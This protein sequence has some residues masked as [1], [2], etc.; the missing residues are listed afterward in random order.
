MT[1]LLKT[2]TA[3][4]NVELVRNCK[5][6]EEMTELLNTATVKMLLEFNEILNIDVKKSAKKSEIINRIVNRLLNEREVEAFK[7][8]SVNKRVKYLVANKKSQLN[9]LVHCDIDELKA[10]V[11]ALKISDE[12]I[13]KHFSKCLYCKEEDKYIDLILNNLEL[14]KNGNAE[15]DENL[16]N[17]TIIISELES[18]SPEEKQEIL[19]NCANDFLEDLCWAYGYKPSEDKKVMANVLAHSSKSIQAKIQTIE[20]ILPTAR[21]NFDFFTHIGKKEQAESYSL[22]LKRLEVWLKFYQQELIRSNKL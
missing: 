16:N 6:A 9:L 12:D 15:A 7:E 22:C 17:A 8:M 2:N 3:A 20:D 18:K 1:K 14:L 10:L 4:E 21:M 13:Q 19:E 11:Q 5:T